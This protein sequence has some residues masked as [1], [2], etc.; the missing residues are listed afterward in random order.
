METFIILTLLIISSV[1]FGEKGAI[2]LPSRFKKLDRKPFNC[3]PCLT[4]HL[5]WFLIA[6]YALITQSLP[7]LVLGFVNALAVFCVVWCIDK[8][9]IEK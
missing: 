4:F 2:Y 1:Y 6:L 9:K 3:R 8:S 5:T 7:L